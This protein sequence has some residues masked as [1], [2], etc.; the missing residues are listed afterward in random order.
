LEG[1]PNLHHQKGFLKVLQA[2]EQ[3]R[4]PVPGVPQVL[5]DFVPTRHHT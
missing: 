5:Q 1:V 4:Q 2:K 3:A